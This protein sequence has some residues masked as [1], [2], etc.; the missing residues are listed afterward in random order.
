MVSHRNQKVGLLLYGKASPKYNHSIHNLYRLVTYELCPIAGD[1]GYPLEPFLLTPFANPASPAEE[2]YNRSHTATRVVV[3]QTFGLLKSR[4]RCLHRSGGS[5]QYKP[6]KCAQIAVACMLLHNYCVQRR[7]PVQDDLHNV[8]DEL[9]DDD[10]P[11]Q[12]AHAVNFGQGYEAR[13]E[14]VNRVFAA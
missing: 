6:L 14:L 7:I 5:L 8:D 2:R 9:D 3:E 13:Q 11:Q 10:P 12:V 4:F 1:S